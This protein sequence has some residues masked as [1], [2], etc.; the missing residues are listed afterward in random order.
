MESLLTSPATTLLTILPCV[1]AITLASSL[2][3]SYYRLRHIPGPFIPSLTNWWSTINIWT[4]YEYKV[5]IQDL[6]SKYGSVVRWG[7]NR[8]S[9]SQPAAIPDI[10]GINHPFPKVLL[11]CA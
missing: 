9:F 5:F 6:H 3:R 11:S 7:P 4:G 8:V 2:V 1:L 10:Y